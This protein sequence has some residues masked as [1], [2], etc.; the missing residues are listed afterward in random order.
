ML[1]ADTH[2]IHNMNL[3]SRLINTNFIVNLTFEFFKAKCFCFCFSN[4]ILIETNTLYSYIYHCFAP[5]ETKLL[6]DVHLY[7][8]GKSYRD[9][10]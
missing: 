4:G 9:E 2:D 7:L 6:C 3:Q 5:M 10:I 1:S 8:F